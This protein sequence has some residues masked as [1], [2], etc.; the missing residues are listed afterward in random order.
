MSFIAIK[1]NESLYANPEFLHNCGGKL[2]GI[3]IYDDS[4]ITHCCEL[5]PSYWFQLIQYIS[6]TIPESETKAE[7]LNNVLMDVLSEAE[8]GGY[9]HCSMINSFS[10]QIKHNLGDF[11]SIDDAIEA[12]YS[13]PKW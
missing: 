3:Y 1:L 7:E 6:E 10:E 9:F 8:S 4:S 11:D 2:Y 5:T 12:Y 13:N